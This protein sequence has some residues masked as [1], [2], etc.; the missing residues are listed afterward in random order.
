M[1]NKFNKNDVIERVGPSVPDRG[2]IRGQRYIVED[3]NSLVVIVRDVIGGWDDENF[4]LIH[5]ANSIV[6]EYPL[7]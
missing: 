5:K 1:A 2:M 3:H 4:K 7:F 6:T